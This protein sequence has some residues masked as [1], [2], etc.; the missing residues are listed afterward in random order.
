V[1]RALGVPLLAAMRPE[2][3]LARA[4]ERG[5]APGRPRGPLAGAAR[6]VLAELHAI[7]GPTAGV[8]S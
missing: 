8:R 7:A 5:A 4:L 1:S 6:T 3:G 2:P